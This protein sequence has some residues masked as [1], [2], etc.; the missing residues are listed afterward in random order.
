MARAL[1]RRPDLLLVHR[2]LMQLDPG[3]QDAI[4]NRIVAESR[5]AE[6]RPGFGILWS[7]E[8]ETLSRHFDR[9]VRMENGRIAEDSGTR[10][11]AD[12]RHDDKREPMRAS[13]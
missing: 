3:S 2:G 1:L 7:L 8:S 13:A 10:N 11:G 12:Q 6:G 5:G 9:V 4:V